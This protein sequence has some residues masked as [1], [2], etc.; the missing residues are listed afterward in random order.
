M[1]ELIVAGLELGSVIKVNRR[2]GKSER[3]RADGKRAQKQ[4]LLFLILTK[5]LYKRY[6]NIINY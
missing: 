3:E 5:I 6:I 2:R 4:K 1:S